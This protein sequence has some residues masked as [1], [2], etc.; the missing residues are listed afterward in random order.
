MRADETPFSTGWA[1]IE[2]Q[3]YRE[4]PEPATYSLFDY[5]SLP[6][7]PTELF[8]GDFDWLSA[9]RRQPAESSQA[10]YDSE[11][12]LISSLASEIG[13]E[14]PESFVTFMGSRELQ[15]RIRSCTDCHFK[16]LDCIVEYPSGTNNYLIPFLFDSQGMLYWYLY[17]TQ[18]SKHCVVVSD[19]LLGLRSENDQNEDSYEEEGMLFFCAPTFEEFLYRFWI[20]NEIWFALSYEKTK[21]TKEQQAYV[22]HYKKTISQ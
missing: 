4:H 14:L 22:D 9:P 6:P 3:G 16:L 15:S 1:S 13:F 12:D 2:L 8:N 21:L 11:L 18:D 17:V 20:E 7:V 5:K 10:D 19:E